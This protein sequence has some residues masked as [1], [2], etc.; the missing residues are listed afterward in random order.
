MWIEFPGFVFIFNGARLYKH[1]P[2]LQK[3]HNC[4]MLK[5]FRREMENARNKVFFCNSKQIFAR[6][7]IKTFSEHELKALWSAQ[8]F[9]KHQR[10]SIHQRWTHRD[11]FWN[12]E[13][14]PSRLFHRRSFWTSRHRPTRRS[15]SRSFSCTSETRRLLRKYLLAL[16]AILIIS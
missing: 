9:L 13:S 3:K 5:L 1:L 14:A 16:P 12:S 8:I 2:S 11:P 7:M 4:E 10:G 6:G 15:S